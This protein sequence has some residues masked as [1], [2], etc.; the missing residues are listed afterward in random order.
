[1]E[2]KW[3]EIHKGM[4]GAQIIAAAGADFV[5]GIGGQ[6]ADEALFQVVP[7]AT[8]DAEDGDGFLRGAVSS[9]RQRPTLSPCCKPW[10]SFLRKG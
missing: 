1:M 2:I 5:M 4:V 10:L 7:P 8:M 9:C 6:P 3:A